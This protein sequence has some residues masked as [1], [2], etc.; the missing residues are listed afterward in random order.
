MVTAAIHLP[1]MS[2]GDCLP[3]LEQRDDGWVLAGPGAENFDLVN[4]YLSHVQKLV[5]RPGRLFV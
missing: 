1:V 4:E 2:T 3:R 5:P